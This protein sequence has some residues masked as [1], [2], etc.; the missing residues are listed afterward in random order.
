MKKTIFT[1]VVCGFL[2][3]AANLEINGQSIASASKIKSNQARFTET[4][5][6]DLK[7]VDT[8]ALKNVPARAL[9]D[10]NKKYPEGNES[11]IRSDEGF[12]SVFKNEKGITK[13]FYNKKGILTYLLKSYSEKYLDEGIRARVKR[14]YFD[15]NIMFVHEI[16][17]NN[18][19]SEPVYLVLIRHD[20]DGKWLRI[21]STGM[22]VYEQINYTDK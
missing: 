6:V 1:M 19:G 8:L 7:K 17:Q 14:Q 13:S 20:K 3:L 16:H 9:S 4:V 12:V 5:P 15:H 18:Y 11:W 21:S 10:F 2:T 22:D